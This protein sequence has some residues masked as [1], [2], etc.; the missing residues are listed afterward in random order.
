M[1]VIASLKKEATVRMRLV[2]APLMREATVNMGLIWG[3]N[4][5]SVGGVVFVWGEC[6][7]CMGQVWL[8]EISLSWVR[9]CVR[10]RNLVLDHFAIK[11]KKRQPQTVW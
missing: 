4:G 11:H 9:A 3:G 5:V 7:A 6:G 8:M 10:C 2:I 1:R